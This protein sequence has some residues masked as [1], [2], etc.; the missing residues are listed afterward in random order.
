MEGSGLRVHGVLTHSVPKS[1]AMNQ[2]SSDTPNSADATTPQES[3]NWTHQPKK[4][5]SITKERSR[6]PAE[7]FNECSG[8]VA[9]LMAEAAP[10][11]E[12]AGGIGVV[13]GCRYIVVLSKSYVE[14]STYGT[15]KTENL[16]NTE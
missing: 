7:R 4:D 1:W 10:V 14:S 6:L 3:I 12:G 8:M 16:S 5:R 13:L 9:P 2:S 15:P 11:P